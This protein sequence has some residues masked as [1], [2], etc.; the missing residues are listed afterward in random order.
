[1]LVTL[2]GLS[3]IPIIGI[4]FLGLILTQNNKFIQA[5]NNHSSK[6]NVEIFGF[7]P[8]WT[9]SKIK[10]VDWNTLS[11]FA[12]FSLPVTADGSIDRNSYEFSVFEKEQ[13]DGLFAEAKKH[14]VRRVITLTQMEPMTIEA[15]LNNRDSW[16]KLS[17]ET[18]QIL[19]A[20]D[21]DG[22]NIDFEYI[23]SNNLLRDKFSDFVSYYSRYL[24]D[25]LKNPYITVSVLASSVRFNRIYD[26]EELSKTTDG[27]M[28]MAYDFYYPGSPT[29]GPTAPL[30]GFNEGKGPFWYDVS[31]A[32]D[33]F[34]K[35]APAE[36][37]IM[38]IPYYGWNY[39]AYTP[40]PKTEKIAW[41]KPSA[42]TLDKAQKEKLLTVTPIGG[43][44]SQAQV[45]WKGYWDGD[46]WQVF[47]LEDKN[48]LSKKYDLVN[49]K[50]L[51]GVGL[52]ALGY[53]SENDA[54][55]SLL[56][57]KFSPSN[58]EVQI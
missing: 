1:M 16:E 8:Y 2:W 52:W 39:P 29:I 9:L 19:A 36:K 14:Q 27:V 7:A 58:H 22:V 53:E 25:N 26:I 33:D 20:R 32:V 5:F 50:G 15:F 13:L 54:V 18:V 28:M 35:V 40:A 56:A 6:S 30:Y 43:W 41:T 45:A 21:L 34:L 3:M 24:K 37:I 31:T 12:Y 51:G 44:D 57:A 10:N 11:T 46:N 48:S 42:T 49:E 55:W 47:Y 17:Q 38:G 4:F 23:P